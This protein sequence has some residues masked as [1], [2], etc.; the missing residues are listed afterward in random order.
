MHRPD[1]KVRM[2]QNEEA[3]LVANLVDEIF[4]LGGESLEFETVFPYWLVAEIA[5]EIVGTINLR[6]SLPVSSVEMMSIDP[7]L[8][9]RERGTV[10]SM[11]TDSAVAICAAS[12]ASMVSSMIPDS[13]P[14]YLKVAKR[15]GYV[16]GNHGSIVFGRTR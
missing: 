2:A 5:G 3:H 12:G 9:R 14:S 16:V 11:L 4:N 8:D 1:V 7:K 10:S 15:R 13:L 6:I